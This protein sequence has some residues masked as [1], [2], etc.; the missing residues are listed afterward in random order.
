MQQVHLYFQVGLLEENRI[1]YYS[2]AWNSWI[3]QDDIQGT[4][5]VLIQKI[6]GT[7]LEQG[8]NTIF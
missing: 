6:D 3:V 1:E 5:L 7:L 8:N 4:L 2:E